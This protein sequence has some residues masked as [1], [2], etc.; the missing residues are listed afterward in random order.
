[1]SYLHLPP[2]PHLYLPPPP[3]LHLPPPQGHFMYVS[4]LEE[5]GH[6]L[7]RD[8]YTTDHLH[9]DMY[10]MFDNRLVSTKAICPHSMCLFPFHMS[11]P[12]PCVSVPIPC[13]SVTLQDWERKYI[14]ENWTKVL[15][16]DYMLLQV[17][18]A[19]PLS[20]T[21]T[22]PYP[23]ITSTSSP[24]PPQPCPDV[25]WFPV[26]TELFTKHLVEASGCGHYGC[27]HMPSPPPLGDGALWSV[28]LWHQ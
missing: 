25:Y 28:E 22:S 8:S 13:V 27:G 11:V 6:L 19:I 17:H 2:P 7:N 21:P 20:H 3:H 4:N 26:M 1:M 18:A 9:N 5:Y 10:Q 14:H 12:I 15:E 16:P 23:T 24:S